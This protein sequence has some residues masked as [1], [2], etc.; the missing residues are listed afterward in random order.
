MRCIVSGSASVPYQ[1][2]IFSL[3]LPSFFFFFVTLNL[4]CIRERFCITFIFL[5]INK[6]DTLLFTSFVSNSLPLV[7]H[8]GARKSFDLYQNY[9]H[10]LNKS[11]DMRKDLVSRTFMTLS[12]V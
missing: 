10:N 6:S 7:G 1:I 11:K 4:I 9:N 12:E 3:L 5:D 2:E 8:V